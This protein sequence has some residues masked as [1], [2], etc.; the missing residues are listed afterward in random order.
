MA[1]PVWITSHQANAVAV[2]MKRL[3]CCPDISVALGGVPSRY[4]RSTQFAAEAPEY[5]EQ[6][7]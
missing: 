5:L 1:D 3:G 6:V 4:S 2:L 7:M